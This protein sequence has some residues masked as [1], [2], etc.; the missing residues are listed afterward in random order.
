MT[1]FTQIFGGSAVSPADV[2]YAAY[3]FNSSLVLFWPQFS[4]GQT[5]VAARFMNL[6]ATAGS[7]NVFMPDA[8]LVSVGY[9]VVIFNAGANT[10]NVVSFTGVSIATIAP[11][12]TYYIILNGNTTQTGSWQTVQFGV[13]TGSA[14]AAALA[15]AGLLAAAGLLDVNFDASIVSTNYSITSSNRAI[16]QVWSGGSGTITLPTAA[17]VGDGFFFPL[18]NN[19]SGSVTIATSGSDQ[20]DGAST[21][22]FAQTQS[23]FIVSSGTAW[24]TVGKGIQNTFSV[25]LL[26]LN[27]AG[28][29][30]VTET[31]AQ[32]QNII[33]QFTGILTGNIQVIVPNTVQLYYIFNNTTGPFTLT[34]I[35]AAGTGVAVTQ[36]THSILYCDGTNVVN[37]FTSSFGGGISLSAGTANAPNLNFIGSTSTGI[38]SP[39]AN[40]IALTAGGFE[41]LNAVSNP[42]SVNFLQVAASST[43]APVSLS[44]LGSDS[45]IS[46]A[47]V[48][49]GSGAITIG[50]VNI[51]GGT[52]DNTV[53]GGSTPAAITGTS[54]T[55]TGTVKGATLVATASITTAGT[56]SAVSTI[57]GSRLASTVA[58]G[59]S[60]LIVTSTTPVPNLFASGTSNNAVTNA[61]LAQMA[62]DTVKVNNTNGT[63]NA[64]DLS[65]PASTILA[66]LAS[67]DIVAATVTQAR[68]LLGLG[69]TYQ[70]NPA[71]PTSTTSTTQ[72]MMG[73]GD[74]FTP[75][76][77]TMINITYT[78]YATSTV[79]N[80]IN[81]RLSSGTGA[82]PANGAALT[83]TQ[84]GFNTD[85]SNCN[86]NQ[87][88][89]FS[90]TRILS[91]LSQG[92][93]YWFDIA[94]AANTTGTVS[95]HN[96]SCSIFE[97]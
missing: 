8:T 88:V 25:T 28:S 47:L 2:A 24:Y 59:T 93:T 23:A 97:L 13:G 60:P 64:T 34:L 86:A 48:P 70:T 17:S 63:A 68:T 32:A 15:G 6:T 71:D 38:Y 22:V 74:I 44:A 20:I 51:S 69:N 96:L 53:I 4:A 41:V 85:T 84:F 18:A 73:L 72:V 3:S 9:N 92:T 5:N 58:T 80:G 54:I 81:A 12:Q 19:G 79:T 42:S 87:R 35:T 10:F 21:S 45:S 11:G 83:G 14:S 30:N 16:L 26:N 46:F 90:I 76:V 43:G 29:S 27:V 89:P 65:M 39:S 66:R 67:G 61:M 82:V 77:S 36:G 78:G 52:I 49:K 57:T 50:N 56:I 33:Q 91:G 37:A 31:S 95:I 55:G 62:A 94:L 75:V 40:Q 1:S 7:L